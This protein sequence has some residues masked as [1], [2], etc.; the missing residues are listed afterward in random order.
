MDKILF[1]NRYIRLEQLCIKDTS[2]K[3]K[4]FKH[5]ITTSLSKHFVNGV[6]NVVRPSANILQYN[7]LVFKAATSGNFIHHG[8]LR[9]LK[10]P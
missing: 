6:A 8:S 9:E 10:I 3:P 7:V 2:H 4:T 1:P 5:G